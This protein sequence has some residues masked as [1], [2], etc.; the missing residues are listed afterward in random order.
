[1][2]LIFKP[3]FWG[4]A[5]AL[6]LG[7]SSS[8]ALTLGRVRGAALLGQPLDVAVQVQYANEEDVGSNC[9]EAEVHYGETALETSR[10]QVSVQPTVNAKSQLV[11]VTSRALIDEAVVRLTVKA[12]CGATA[13]RQY[14]LLSDLVSELAEAG[15]SA[16][17][18]SPVG[19]GV[20]GTDSQM[21][22]AGHTPVPDAAG[23]TAPVVA[24]RNVK[25]QKMTSMPRAVVSALKPS[26]TV[27][28]K[29]GSSTNASM[30]A[31]ALEDLTRRVDEIA[32]WQASSSNVDE[33]LKSDARAKALEAEMRGLKMVT[34]KNQQNFQVL[35]AAL[36]ANSSQSVGRSLAYGL[37]AL[38]IM[39]IAALVYVGR[40][41]RTTTGP[42][43]A[44]WWSGNSERSAA[45][46]PA[47]RRTKPVPLKSDSR[48]A[49]LGEA[50]RPIDPFAYRSGPT[51]VDPQASDDT[52][53]GALSRDTVVATTA[54]LLGQ[55]AGPLERSNRSDFAP[56]G[57][58]MI[59]A[60]NTREM[61]DVRQQ[62]EFFMALGQHDEAVRLLESN[63]RGSAD[64]NPLVFLDLL[65]IFHTL[66]RRTEFER[67]R[68]EFNAQFTGRIPPYASFLAEGNGLEAY[69]DICNQIVVLWPTEYT[70]DYIEQCLVRLPEDAPDQ[71]IDLEA[72]KDLLMLYGVL[73]R[74]DQG[75]DSGHAP[76]SASR[77]DLPHTAP[78]SAAMPAPQPVT[79]FVNNASASPIDI[80]LDL[81]LDISAAD[82]A[83][84]SQPDNNLID[85]DMS[86]YI[87]Q[88]KAEAAK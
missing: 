22:N 78:P 34:A 50:P 85:F 25:P 23:Q 21:T 26:N 30:N 12:K 75:N 52:D 35:A 68:E 27:S 70:I 84:P 43:T 41:M 24:A 57:T 86:E 56:S 29:S 9:F 83:G 33:A 47:A 5:V 40:R 67:Y 74:L 15:A 64:C 48:S 77:I 17:A 39:L 82:V 18:L 65:K 63:I 62:A 76:F 88:K 53:P 61:L 59:R 73:K 37:G 13:S 16:P 58:G 1:M 66:S 3:A 49:D 2:K 28:S 32:K 60:I 72:F 36:E 44:P 8:D 79:A 51:T 42:A 38:L 19:S 4:T 10:I 6:L 7:S 69:L 80:D 46:I 55:Q 11:R 81:D 31:S 14:V 20:R 87:A 45:Q 54:S 71:G